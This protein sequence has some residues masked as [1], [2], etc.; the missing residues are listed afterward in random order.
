M[1]PNIEVRRYPTR[2]RGSRTGLEHSLPTE[3]LSKMQDQI[4]RKGWLCSTHIITSY[5]YIL[6]CAAW[7]ANILR[8]P[9]TKQDELVLVRK[10]QNQHN[11]TTQHSTTKHS[12]TQRDQT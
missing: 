1:A 4:P 7:S 3:W 6:M 8:T 12:T 9:S 11:T 2:E 5:V 10:L